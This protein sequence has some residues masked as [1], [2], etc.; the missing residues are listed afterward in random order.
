MHCVRSYG[1]V[2]S[3]RNSAVHIA[4]SNLIYLWLCVLVCAC[5]TWCIYIYMYICMPIWRECNQWIVVFSGR[6]SFTTFCPSE[7]VLRRRMLFVSTFD[8]AN[9][10]IF[11]FLLLEA[12]VCVGFSIHRMFLVATLFLVSVHLFSLFVCNVT[13]CGIKNLYLCSV[14]IKVN[15]SYFLHS[16]SCVRILYLWK[17]AYK[18][19]FS[20]VV[21]HNAI[22]ILNFQ[23]RKIFGKE[24]TV[25]ST[26]YIMF[27]RLK[28]R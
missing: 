24:Y 27:V 8:V 25:C 26:M 11:I 13:S 20:D 2:G 3:F 23:T 7:D 10:P 19:I 12:V 22:I 17:H 9:V 28:S 15:S 16:H 4:L 5:A 18:C 6:W 1:T 14:V 21:L